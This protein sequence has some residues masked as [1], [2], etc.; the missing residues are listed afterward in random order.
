M[1]TGSRPF[2]HKD[3]QK[4]LEMH[5]VLEP[6]PPRTVNPNLPQAVEDIVL[7]LLRKDPAE[8]I[9]TCTELTARLDALTRVP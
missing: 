5:L 6:T 4:V 8:R 9:A 2:R 1:V 7:G 3:R